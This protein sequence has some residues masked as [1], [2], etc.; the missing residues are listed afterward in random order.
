MS[1]RKLLGIVNDI[2]D[3]KQNHYIRIRELLDEAIEDSVCKGRILALITDHE[4]CAYM[5]GRTYQEYLHKRYLKEK[6]ELNER[7]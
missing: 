1:E 7:D 4:E 3:E 2:V 6:G 5:H